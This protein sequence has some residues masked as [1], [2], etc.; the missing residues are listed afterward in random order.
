LRPGY[1]EIRRLPA[2]EGTFPLVKYGRTEM[3]CCTA[4]LAGLAWLLAS[5]GPAGAQGDVKRYSLTADD[6][7]GDSVKVESTLATKVKSITSDP[8]VKIPDTDSV[9]RKRFTSTVLS[10]DSRK[11]ATAYRQTYQTYRS[12][13]AEPT[14]PSG[15]LHSVEGKTVVITRKGD[16]SAVTVQN[17]T[18]SADDRKELENTFSRRRN[19]LPA[20]PVAVGEGWDVDASVLQSAF[21]IQ[22]GKQAMHGTLAET[23]E[24]RGHL[25]ARLR[26]TLDLDGPTNKS[27]STMRVN[28]Q[29]DVFYALDLHRL[30]RVTLT[31][32]IVAHTKA[33]GVDIDSTGSIA[34]D[35][36]Y[37]WLK[38][39]GA[40]VPVPAPK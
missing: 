19:Y 12:E 36:T 21:G 37:E 17:G 14:D 34:G 16:T 27:G 18:I 10:V 7:V 2:A 35:E 15:G 9:E 28:L 24:Y 20:H 13:P 26:L 5:I 1:G 22:G 3:R 23:T 31:G 6:A 4:A 33:S 29:V 32:P 8:E 30:L 39:S 38:I 11:K 40:P 25:C